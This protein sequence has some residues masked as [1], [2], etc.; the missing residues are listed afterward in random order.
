M[1]LQQ[2]TIHNIASIE[3][4]FIDFE[5]QP[6]SD[7]DVFLITGKTGSGKSTIL[8]AICLALY[9]D[10]PRLDNTS[11][12]G[13]LE[14]P[15][16]DN[17]T[18]KDP[19][20]IMR[21]NTGEAY[22]SLTF[23]GNNNIHYQATWSV[24]RAN[25]KITGKLQDKKWELKNLSTGNILSKDK[26]IEKEIIAAIGLDFKQFCRTTMLAQGEFTRFLNSKDKDKAA[27]LEKITGVDIYSKIGAKIFDITRE[28]KKD[29]ESAEKDIDNITTLSN[30]EIQ[31][32][33]ET[34][35]SLTTESQ[36]LEDTK[37]SNT[38]KIDWINKE[39][40]LTQKEIEANEAYNDAKAI[41]EKD[42]FK[43][44]E[45]T[46]AEWNDT[47]EARQWLS[48]KNE[49]QKNKNTKEQQL[50]TLQLQYI[51]ALKGL[52]FNKQELN[53][54]QSSITTTQKLIDAEKDKST[55]YENAQTII[56]DLN[57]I[58][59]YLNSIS[60]YQN[61]LKEKNNYLSATLQ[62]ALEK[63]KSDA[64]KTKKECEKQENT[65]KEQEDIL[66]NLNLSNLYKEQNN[67][68][69][70][71]N[72]IDN[73]IREINNLTE[74]KE[75]QESTRL[76]LNNRLSE[77]NEKQE[78]LSKLNTTINEAKIKLDAHKESYDK[79]KDS[80]DDFASAIR[81]KLHL[82]DTC[83]VCRQKIDAELPLDEEISK[84]VS[85]I[86]Q[87]FRE[88]EENY[89][90]L[91]Q[92]KNKLEAEI[93][94]DTEAYNRD[95]KTFDNDQSVSNAETAVLNACNLCNI[96]TFDDTTLATLNS[97]K[98][99]TL[100]TQAEFEA[101]ISE[102][103]NQNEKVK[104]LR[105]ST[106]E[107]NE[108]KEKKIEQENK[109][110]SAVDECNSEIN[111]IKTLIK[112][113]NEQ[114]TQAQNRISQSITTNDWSID[115]M[116][117]PLEFAQ[118]LKT[119]AD[120]YN[121]NVR[122]LNDLQSKFNL[123]ESENSTISTTI[124]HIKETIPSWATL[125]T[126]EVVS[127]DNLFTF[128]TNISNSLTETT[129]QLNSALAIIDDRTERLNQFF[130]D[131]PY[132]NIDRLDELN[133]LSSDQ[134]T[135]EAELLNKN[136]NNVT[137]TQSQLENAVNAHKTHQENKPTINEEDTLDNLNTHNQEIDELLRKNNQEIGAINQE[138]RTDKENKAKIGK[139]KEE[140]KAKEEIYLKWT[141][142]NNL[143]GDSTGDKFRKIAQSYVLSN[144]IHSANFYMKT[145]TDRY[146]LKVTPGTFLISIEDAYQG[147]ASRVAN[148]ISGGES[149]L[150][151][152][153]L[154]LALSDI[155]ENLSVD[156]LFID[157]GFGTLSGNALQNAINTLRNLHTKAGRHVGIISHVEELKEKIP[158]QIQ[159][160]QEGNS[161]SSKIKIIPEI[162]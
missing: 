39:N 56:A 7:S 158:V 109:A 159:V 137:I 101:K 24:H 5:A 73:A 116:M 134:I 120:T 114:I 53:N 45:N 1:K 82:G 33:E 14:S 162:N 113:K 13:E 77:I 117:S 47:I 99:E 104:A 79:Q 67:I 11:M 50:A 147:F 16:D 153:S 157:E 121:D 140:A 146:T 85:A 19:R 4:A 62:P 154:A 98:E 115:W 112:D 18:T 149:F 130:T 133:Q 86:E 49:A 54:L 123:T 124:A 46:V 83:P 144:L 40:E 88:A 6:L 148:T 94:A 20:Q 58:E 139:L 29:W 96:N 17:M 89:N 107:L 32:K 74:Q 30:E 138:L 136:R 44:R 34:I 132:L 118:L 152:L 93:K 80:I 69:Q 61:T 38:T 65:L 84:L 97:L 9:A 2:L 128:V 81:H 142:L 57:S 102:A 52:N 108:T 129:T 145:L 37:K 135:T 36:K 60:E 156:T 3:D 105:E 160:L 27:I 100:K 31:T 41:V 161:S 103:E 119:S 42:E 155:A 111:T 55:I 151:S 23:I 26:E 90:T 25:K 28:K 125:V 35:K 70:H 48:E 66:T 126:D 71:I 150:V 131:K 87:N 43:H 91:N 92:Q 12:E 59:S 68:G 76:A 64:E 122:K 63:A 143:I 22:V 21:R 95:K 127:K 15:I 72:N 51:D 8:D 106:K 78:K 10:T 75:K 110:Q 141:Q